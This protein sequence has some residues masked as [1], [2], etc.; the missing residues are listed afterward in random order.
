MEGNP[1]NYCLC[2]ARSYRSP[3]RRTAL[4]S[5]LFAVFWGTYCKA[6]EKQVSHATQTWVQYYGSATL[7]RHWSLQL[8]GGLRWK[9][10][11]RE[12]SAYIVRSSIGYAPAPN[13]RLAAGLA[14]LG[15]YLQ[16]TL[17][18]VEFRP[19]QD[20]QVT[21]PFRKFSLVHRLR[22]EER[23]FYP[24]SDGR[25]Q[26]TDRFTFR[27]RYAAFVRI[28]LFR[29]S[30]ENPDSQFILEL[31]DELFLNFGPLVTHTH[32]DQNRLLVSPTFR[33]NK[34]FAIALTWNNQ[35]ASTQTP[36]VYAHNQVFWLQLR[37]QFDFSKKTLP[38]D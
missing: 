16:D 18:R 6:Q 23:L 4:L 25:I 37:Q 21:Q 12:N 35:F 36:S 15:L 19:Y 10:D 26:A 38:A 32:F 14:H 9:D 28:P 3:G 31:G 7:N 11:F 17:S 30:K 20:F 2:P 29:L 5:L 27:L 24:V 13:M 33:F 8:D 34:S 1:T 22:L